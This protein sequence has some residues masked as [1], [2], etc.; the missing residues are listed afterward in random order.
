MIEKWATGIGKMISLC[1]D[2]NLPEPKFEEYSGGFEV[3]FRFAEPISMPVIKTHTKVEL[4]S[5][6][7]E[8]LSIIKKHSTANIQQIMHNLKDPPS[9]T[10]IKRDLDYLK[11]N[12]FVSLKGSARNAVWILA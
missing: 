11:K 1:K 5:R 12:G 2:A 10:M 9:R 8:I 3:T 6:Q 7:Q 4:S